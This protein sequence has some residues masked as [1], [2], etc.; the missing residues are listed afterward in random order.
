MARISSTN[1]TKMNKMNR[2]AQDSGL[3]TII[4]DLQGFVGYAGSHT[5]TTAEANASKVIIDTGFTTLTS[6]MIQGSRS[7]SNVISLYTTAGSVSGT[8]DVS[9]ASGL[10]LLPN[11]LIFVLASE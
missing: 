5:V 7:G 8:L 9:A 2:V 11:D 10:K 1:V 6:W 3:G 4:D